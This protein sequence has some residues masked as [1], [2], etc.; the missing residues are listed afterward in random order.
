[1]WLVSKSRREKLNYPGAQEIQAQVK[2]GL[3]MK[4]IGLIGP[5]GP[6]ARHDTEIFAEQNS[7]P[8]GNV[9]SGCPSP[10]LKTNIAMGYVPAEY[11]TPGTKLFCKIRDKM[12]ESVVTKMPFVKTNYYVKP[13]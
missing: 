13:K 4:R 12:Y 3:K 1:M 10:T 6:P 7:T 11:S 2:A 9:T 5:S 8:I